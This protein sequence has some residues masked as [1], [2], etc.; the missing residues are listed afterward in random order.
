MTKE[1]SAALDKAAKDLHMLLRA[2]PDAEPNY[3][4]SVVEEGN[5]VRTT[6]FVMHEKIHPKDR[7][8]SQPQ[9]ANGEE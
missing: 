6:L 7:Y 3:S 5:D 4:V 2:D 8:L 1:V 9:G